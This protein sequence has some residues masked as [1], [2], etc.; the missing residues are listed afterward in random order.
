MG[1]HISI[2]ETRWV[3]CCS[4]YIR[5]GNL[6][7][8][9]GKFSLNRN[10]LSFKLTSPTFL[11]VNGVNIAGRKWM[12]ISLGNK[13]LVTSLISYFS[14]RWEVSSFTAERSENHFW[15]KTKDE[16]FSGS[17]AMLSGCQR[18]MFQENLNWRRTR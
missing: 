7:I 2:L 9:Q 3:W 18:V 10:R 14:L 15:E 17:F 13:I 12:L 1:S 4:F 16:D 6:F 5:S 11:N 8:Y